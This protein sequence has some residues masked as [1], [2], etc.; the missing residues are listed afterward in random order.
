MWPP[1]FCDGG[2]QEVVTAEE[3]ALT[4]IR[5]KLPQ[6]LWWCLGHC[7]LNGGI[8]CARVSAHIYV[9][10]VFV[11]YDKGNMEQT[12]Q[13]SPFRAKSAKFN[14]ACPRCD[15]YTLGTDISALLTV[16]SDNCKVWQVSNIIF[17]ETLKWHVQHMG[18]WH[19]IWLTGQDNK[20]GKAI[21]SQVYTRVINAAPKW[22][23]TLKI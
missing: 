11:F 23:V 16:I 22:N 18:S 1:C 8:Y 7:C 21:K 2:G 17:P 4:R 14:S 9:L 6:L 20:V 5:L 12:N 19:S 10:L 13:T 15:F 3:L